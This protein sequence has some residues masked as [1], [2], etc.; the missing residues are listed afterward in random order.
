[1]FAD[2]DVISARQLLCQLTL[3]MLGVFLLV[4]P[5][6]GELYGIK[7]VLCCFL[8]FLLVAV[9]CFFL[10]RMAPAYRH[11]EKSF[12][13]W[14][15]RL[16]GLWFIS[17]FIFT[18]AFIVSVVS[19][20]I[21]VYLVTGSSP[22]LTHAVILLA[23]AMAGIPQVQRRGRMAEACFG[24]LIGIL[25]LLMILCIGQQDWK[26]LEQELVGVQEAAISTASGAGRM[27]TANTE[28]YSVWKSIFQPGKIALGT[29]EFLAVF[30]GIGALP[31]LLN[32]VKDH[33]CK[34]MI[35]GVAIITGFLIMALLLLQGSY[36]TDQV[37][38]RPW[39]LIALI[40]GIRIPGTFLARFDPLWISI[41]LMLMLFSVGTTLFY[42]NYIAKCTDIPIKWYWILL[43]V[44]LVSLV[45]FG[46]Y[47]IKEYYEIL[48]LYIYA[49]TI[50]VLNLV[51]GWWNRRKM[52]RN[53]AVLAL[54]AV[55][56]VCFSGCRRIEP[57]LRSYPLAMGFDW[58]DGRYQVYYAMP[59]LG[60]YTGEGKAEDTTSLL[61]T[62]NG[63]SYEEID[64]LINQSREQQVDLGHVQV[65]LMGE[66]LL[67]Y[68]DAYDETMEYLL[69]Q[70][71]LGSG[72]Y[73]L[74]CQDL[75]AV[76]ET[77]GVM[78]DS[79]GEYL[80]DLIHKASGEQPEVLQ[81]LY[82]AWYN[83]EAAPQLMNVQVTEERIEVEGLG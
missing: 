57:E 46:G 62:Y 13:I 54:M 55:L 41:F 71:V 70:P 33:R 80:A 16:L 38:E 69:E 53:G 15:A 68:A 72:S 18:G 1:M 10:V 4:L 45:D 81:D 66:G 2:N 6:S 36:G 5:G 78:T 25:L 19:D 65:I 24:V 35:G 73:V 76:M 23:C 37:Q 50:L 34:S 14:G 29:Y 30:T 26:Y 39:P 40:A 56:L 58:V 51:L 20:V 31:F 48:L 83:G 61:W 64:K 17:Y 21:D 77:N 60:T 28:S 44:Y 9:Y 12:G 32:K 63:A 8:G 75:A 59:D 43:A 67:G 3:G 42:S 11:P 49:P 82:N 7:G 79:L 47:T 27:I 22:F 74:K 52:M